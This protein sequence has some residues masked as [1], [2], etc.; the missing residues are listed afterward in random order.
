MVVTATV[1]VAAADAAA[2]AAIVVEEGETVQV[3]AWGAPEH[4]MSTVW[5]KL[6][7]GVIF[8][9]KDALCPA[10]MVAE[11]GDAEREKSPADL[12]KREANFVTNMLPQG[13]EYPTDGEVRAWHTT[14]DEVFKAFGVT[15]K[16]TESV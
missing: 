11:V 16:S 3:A 13:A 6:P 2:D 12:P 9:V 4:A 15:G 7:V 8:K 10:A 1:A 14:C 5:L